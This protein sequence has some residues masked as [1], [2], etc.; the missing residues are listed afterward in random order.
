MYNTNKTAQETLTGAAGYAGHQADQAQDLCLW[1][2]Y[3]LPKGT[4]TWMPT[5]VRERRAQRK[6]LNNSFSLYSRTA[7]ILQQQKPNKQKHFNKVKAQ[8][9]IVEQLPL[10]LPFPGDD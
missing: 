8:I 2:T 4:H 5:L 3:P 1:H 6:H 7:D 9:K 10:S